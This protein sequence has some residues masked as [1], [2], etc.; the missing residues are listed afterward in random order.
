MLRASVFQPEYGLMGAGAVNASLIA[1][2]PRS[3]RALGAVA[4]V[5]FRVASRIVNSLGYGTPV[6][7]PTALDGS[8]VILF[9]SSPEQ[10]QVLLRTLSASPINW[11]GKSLVFCDCHAD[12]AAVES[13]RERGAS[14]AG[15]RRSALPAR[16]IVEGDGPALAFAHRLVK[17]LG[18]KAIE[19]G[20]D[21]AGA[22]EAV[23]TLGSA[24]LTPLIDYATGLL[25]QCGVRDSEAPKLAAALFEHTAREY[26]RTGRQSWAWYQRPPDPADI[27]AQVGAAGGALSGL[28]GEMILFGM[29]ESGRHRET[30]Q[31]I[32]SAIDGREDT[33]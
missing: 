27:V 5:S 3:T 8:R 18:S 29:E 31:A 23:L 20:S 22:F 1:R 17:D 14:V 2:L 25:R 24:A 7:T 21:C 28:L 26:A 4:A 9:H 19:I 12:L 33:E 13:F 16:L 11:S 6:R 32:R 10:F 30:T 15:V